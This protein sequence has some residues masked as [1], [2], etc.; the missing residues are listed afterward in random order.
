MRLED[1]TPILAAIGNHEEE[2][3]QAVE[4]DLRRGDPGRQVRRAQEPRA[5]ERPARLRH[6]R[7]GQ[8]CGRAVVPA[9]RLGARTVTLELTIDTEISQVMEYFEIFLHRMVMCRR[10]AET[11]RL[12]VQ[13]HCE[14]G[15]AAVKAGRLG[16]SICPGRSSWSWAR[17]RG[18][19][20]GVEAAAR[21]GPQ[22]RP[23][24]HAAGAVERLEGRHAADR[25]P[26]PAARRRAGRRR[27]RHLAAGEQ[28]R[29]GAAAGRREPRHGQAAG[30]PVVRL[31][32]AR[33]SRSAATRPRQTP[34]RRR[35]R[36]ARAASSRS[37]G[38]TARLEER[39]VI[40]QVAPGNK[41]KDGTKYEDIKL[42]TDDPLK[43]DVWVYQD[44]QRQ[45]EVRRRAPSR[46]C[47]SAPW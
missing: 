14:R 32:V 40:Q 35:R 36:R 13:D 10:A 2:Y 15:D 21:P 18:S 19:S 20:I 4:P 23:V 42:N 44:S 5:Q 24:G 30:Q 9:G 22:G 27:A 16:L 25:R 11:A 1:L 34:R 45:R 6:P 26:H 38:T 39:P 33:A 31:H 8:L 41:A 29:P 12:S 37:I 17:S 28:R 3:G 7:P 43:S 46:R 47:S